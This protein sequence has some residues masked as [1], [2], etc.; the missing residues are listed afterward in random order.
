VREA[1]K[2][3]HLWIL[4]LLDA[5]QAHGDIQWGGEW[6]TKCLSDAAEGGH[7]DLV[8][9][10][11]ERIDVEDAMYVFDD[12][13]NEACEH[14]HISVIE[15]LLENDDHG[16]SHGPSYAMFSAA[17]FGR[18]E[19]V[20]WLWERIT[21]FTRANGTAMDIAATNGHL[22]VM[23]RIETESRDKLKR[24]AKKVCQRGRYPCCTT[25]A[26]DGAAANGHLDVVKWLH[27]YRWEGCTTSA[28][29]RAAA[30]GHL[31]VVQWL[32]WHKNDDG[33]TTD[34]M[35]IVACRHF[36]LPSCSGTKTMNCC[37]TATPPSFY[38]DQLATLSWL[39]WNSL[40]GCTAK[41]MDGAAA[42]GNV[43]VLRLLHDR[44]SECTTKAMDSAAGGDHLD[45]VQWLHAN[46]SEGCTT[47]AMDDA[48]SAGH[49]K[50]VQWLHAN[51][52]EGCTAKAMNM[53]AAHGHLGVVKWLLEH[54]AEVAIIPAMEHA[55]VCKK[56]EV[57]WFL[58][59]QRIDHSVRYAII[60]AITA[61]MY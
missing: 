60:S 50:V 56:L 28:T 24:R 44:R 1:A 35:D 30:N 38:E 51:R 52:P 21:L 45:T 2:G 5:D 16:Q 48:A 17:K 6:A 4:Q 58:D 9:W 18:L 55:I 20:K 43:Q 25:A 46:R 26:M 37:L 31:R 54:R 3:G 7:W 27:A 23:D 33:A 57:M 13:L 39:S 53:A 22:K 8:K 19:V 10:L 47:N 12:A 29:D 32:H 34:T 49:L 11:Y 36:H 15:W 40:E 42:N 41:A 14:A 59:A 61:C